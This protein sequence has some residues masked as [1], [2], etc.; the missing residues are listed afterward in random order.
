[1]HYD[2]TAELLLAGDVDDDD[3]GAIAHEWFNQKHESVHNLSLT[4]TIRC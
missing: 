2:D 4:T 3:D 1:M